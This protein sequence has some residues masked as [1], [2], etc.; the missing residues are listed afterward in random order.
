MDLKE[1]V[2][3][4]FSEQAVVV[5]SKLD[6]YVTVT[7]SLPLDPRLCST[8]VFAVGAEPEFTLNKDDQGNDAVPTGF[9]IDCP[10]WGADGKFDPKG[11]PQLSPIGE[12]KKET[13]EEGT[14]KKDSIMDA[15]DPADDPADDEG[16]EEQTGEEKLNA[17]IKTLQNIVNTIYAE[18]AK[19][20]SAVELE[21]YDQAI[22][23]MAWFEQNN[24]S[25]GMAE[26]LE[27]ASTKASLGNLQGGMQ[28]LYKLSAAANILPDEEDAKEIKQS[29]ENTWKGKTVKGKDGK[30]VKSKSLIDKAKNRIQKSWDQFKKRGKKTLSAAFGAPKITKFGGVDVSSYIVTRPGRTVLLTDSVEHRVHSYQIENPISYKDLC[31]V[32]SHLRSRGY[33]SWIVSDADEL[34]VYAQ[35]GDTLNVGTN[36][37]KHIRDDNMILLLS[38]YELTFEEL[39]DMNSVTPIKMIETYGDRIIVKV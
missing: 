17:N 26:L 33:N 6:D 4:V 24:G 16:E 35:K 8:P 10:A 12:E 34:L 32:F 9:V 29:V 28:K 31:S 23:D 13:E 20:C 37:P 11:V 5:E 39:K 1:V 19:F 21:V 38:R 22:T 18:T 3:K 14:T 25:S 7:V 15:D 30:T 2:K 27:K 36:L